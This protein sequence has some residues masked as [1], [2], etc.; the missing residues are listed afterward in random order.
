MRGKRGRPPKPL[1]AEEPSA[2]AAR[3]LRPR[4]NLK[5]RL[6][7]SGDEESPTRETPKSGRKRKAGSGTAA[8]GRGRGR[9]G[10]GGGGGRGGRGG[11]GGKRAPAS[12]TVVYD[13]HESDEEEDDAVSLRSD[14]EEF[15]EEDPQSE[16]DEALKEDSDCLEED[17]LGD[18]EDDASYCTESSFRSQSTHASTPGKKKVRAPRPRTPIL[19]EKEIPPL[20]LPDTS[21]DLLVPNEE[22]LNATSIYE[23]LRNFS[24]VLR[25]SPFRFEDF[26]AALVGQEQCTLI[27]ETHISLL[28]AIL[29]EEDSSNTTFGPADLK[30]SVNS[31]LYFIDGMT[32]PEVLRAYCES[33]Q[34]YHH[35]LPYLEVDEYPYGPLESKIKLLQFLVD[36]FLTT[37][38]AREELMSDGSMQYD[39][40][41]RVCHRLGDLLCCETCSAVYHL[42]CVKP[43]LEEVPEDEWQCEVCV[44][45]KVPGVT[46][47][48]TE[49]QKIRPYIRQEPVGYDRHQRKYWFLSRRIIVEEDGEH[50][51]KK[52][53]Y[54]STKAQ[55]E[56]LME[57]L[58]KEYWEMDLHATLVE[59]K[60]EV[61]A[62]MDITEDLTNKARGNN[63][64]YLTAVNELVM[65]HLKIR[66]EAQRLAEEPKEEAEKGSGKTA[67]DS[68]ESTSQPDDSE[69]NNAGPK[70]DT[71]S[72][73]ALVPPPAEESCTSHPDPGSASQDSAMPKAESLESSQDTQ[74]AQSRSPE[75]GETP[76][77][78]K[79]ERTDD[80]EKVEP[81][82]DVPHPEDSKPQTKDQ[83]Q[84]QTSQP[85]ASSSSEVSGS[86]SHAKAEPPD[87]AD[88]SSQS[89]FTSQDGTEEYNERVKTDPAKTAGQEMTNQTP[90]ASKESSAT[91]SDGESL[92]L[93]FL[94][95]DLTVNVNSLFKLGQEGKYRVYHNQYSTNVL[96]LNKH[97]HR[98]DHDK[99][100]HLSHKFSLTTASEFKWNG[101]IYGSRSLTVSTLRLT[102]IQLE[103]NV[104]G[105]FMHPNWASHRTNWNKAV[106]M[107]SK[108]REFALALAIL[109]CAIKPVVMLPV[110]KESLGHTRLHRMTSMEREEKEKVKKREKKL[111][112][113]ETLQQA[114]WVKYTIPIKHQVWKQKGEEYR[115]TGYGGWSWVSKTRVPRFVP[116]LPGNTNVNYR[117]KLEGKLSKENAA[118][119][120]NKQKRLMETKEQNAAEED[121]DQLKKQ[122]PSIEEGQTSTE[123]EKPVQEEQEKCVEDEK[124]E[125]DP[126]SEVAASK[127]DKD[128][129]KSPSSPA[130]QPVGEEPIQAV[131]EPKTEETA[132]SKPYYDVV[133]VSEGF[134]L[135]TAY[136]KKVKP[137][138]LDGL[139]ER[140]VKQFTLEEKQRLERMR[141]ATFVSK[142]ATAKPNSGIKSESTALGRQQSAVSPCVKVEEKEDG[143]Q[144]KDPVV[145]K[146]DFEQEAKTDVKSDSTAANHSK[147]TGAVQENSTEAKA[148]REVNGGRLPGAEL[149][150]KSN[151][152]SEDLETKE[153]SQ[154]PEVTRVG[155]NAKKRGYEEVEQGGG[156]S[157]TEVLGGDESKVSPMQVNGQPPADT[158]S[159]AAARLQ[160]DARETQK[161]PLKSLMNGNLCPN[162]ESD[163]CHPPPLKV[164]KLENHIAE[165]GDSSCKN[166]D[167][168]TASEGTTKVPSSS[169]SCLNSNKTDN[170][171]SETSIATG[172][173]AGSV[174]SSNSKADVT[175]PASSGVASSVTAAQPSSVSPGGVV[176]QKTKLPVTDPKM[177]ACG[178]NTA[179]S[180][181][182]SKEYSTRDRVSLLRFSKSKKARSGTALPSYR[183]FVTKSSKKS[184]FVLPN[185]DL[186]RLARRAGFREVPIFN[187][188]AKPA[189]DIWP[190]P[191]PRPTF[192][193]TWRYRL[194]TVRSLAGVSLMLRLLWACLRWDDMAVKP[195]AVV[196]TTRKETTDTDITTTEIIKR[197]DVGPYGIRSEYCI[198]KIICPLGNRDTHKETPT[199]QRKGL[200]SSALRPKKQEPAKL[201]GPIAVETWV[202]EEEL[203]LWEIRAFAERVER[204]KSQGLDPSKTGSSLK[205][206][207]EVK[208]H[209]ENQLKQARLAAQQ[210]RLEQQRPSTPA[211]TSTTTA[212]STAS[213]STP[214]AP[215]ST[216]Q[217]MG[218]VASG[219]KMVLASK[220]GSPVSFQQDKNF[221]QS[222]ASWVK[223][224][225]TNNSAGVVQQKVLGIFPSG[226]P[227]NLRTYS[228]LHPTTGN[229]N[230]RATTSA[231]AA[232]Q[233]ATAAGGQT[234][235][236]TPTLSTSVGT[237]VARSPAMVQQAHPQQAVTRMGLGLSAATAAPG[238]TPAQMAATQRAVAPAL[239]P[240]VAT[241]APGQSPVAPSQAN[242]PQQGQVKLT[243]AQLMQLTQGAQ[244]ANPGLTVVI[245]GQG[246][247]QGQLQIIPQ[248]VT[249]IPGPGQQLMQAAMPNGQV[250]RF[251]FT[252]MPP[253]SS[254]ATSAPATATT[255]KPAVAQTPQTQMPTSASTGSLAQVQTTPS[256]LAHTQM[257]APVPAPTHVVAPASAQ[258]PSLAPP[259]ASVPVQ[260]AANV[261]APVQAAAHQA[262]MQTKVSGVPPSSVPAQSQIP[263]SVPAL[264]QV[265]AQTSIISSLTTQP[266]VARSEAPTAQNSAPAVTQ[267]VFISASAPAPNE[268][269]L[270]A[271]VQTQVST[272]PSASFPTQ[273]Q[274]PVSLPVVG[275][276]AP[277]PQVQTHAL[278]STPVTASALSPVL[279][280]SP[281]QVAAT[282]TLAAAT[283]SAQVQAAASLPSAVPVPTP[284][285]APVS[286]P[287]VA[288]VSTQIPVPSP[289]KALTQIQT[290]AAAPLHAAVASA[291][292][293]PVTATSTT[294]SVPELR[295]A[296]PQV[297]TPAA[298][299]AQTPV[300]PV[301]QAAAPIQA[302]A[303]V[304]VPT[305]PPPSIS[306]HSPITTLPHSSL[307][308]LAPQSQAQVQHPTVVSM[309]QVSQIPVSAV[310][311]HMQGLPVSSVVTAVRPPQPH[312]QPQT[313]TQLQHQ[314]QA[315]IHAQIQ[316]QP[317]GQVQQIQAQAHLQS[318]TQAQIQPQVRVQFQPRSQSQQTPQPQV[319]PLAQIQPQVQFQSQSQSLPQVQAP[320]QGQLQ[321]RVQPQYHPQVQGSFQTQLQ[322]QPQAQQQPQVQPQAQVQAQS[323]A[324]TQIQTQLH[325]QVQVQ[326][327]QQSQIQAQQPQ[328]PSQV[329]TH[330]HF[331]VQSPQQ[332]QVQGQ[333]QV[334]AK[335][336]VQFQPQN[337]T[338]VQPQPQLQVQSPIR[339]QLITVPGLQQ[340]V[341]LLSALP[342]HV[343]AQIQAQIQAQA[344]QQGGT[345]PQQIKLQLPIQI[346]Q[347]GGQI[348]AHQIQNMVTI[349]APVNVQEQLQRMQQ[350]QQ[351]Q[352]QHPPPPKKKKPHESKKEQKEQNVHAVSPGDGIQKQV[353][354]KQNAT[355]EQLKQR[356]TLAAAEREENQ[357]MIVCNQVMKFILDKIEKDEK[358][359]AKKRK[360]E[361]V[362][363][364]KRSKQ[365]ATKLTALLYKHKE[366]LKAEILKKRALLDKELQLQVQEELRR[367]IARLQKEKEKAR[368]AIAQAA[369]ATVKA[370]SSHSSHPS[371][372]THSSHS[373][374]TVTS[375]SSSHIRKREE[376]RD[377][378]RNRDRD[379]HHD[380]EK[381]RDRDKDRDRHRDRDKDRERE[382]ERERDR[383]RD[384]DKDRDR[385][386]D[387]DRDSSS[388]KHKKKKKH[389]STSKDHKKDTKLYCICKTPY[390]ESKFYIGC[391]LCSNWFHGTCVG[392]TEK[393]AK[394]LEDFVCNDCKRGQEAGSSEELYCICRTPYDESQFYIGCDRCQN[395]YHG[396]C[397]GILQSE[398]NHIDVY[399]CPQCQS[400]EDAMTVLTPLTDKDYEGLK[401][402]LRSLQ[403]H[404]MA[405]P[406]LEPVD[407]HDAPDYYRV[408]KE[409]M[410]F[411][412]METRLQKR[413]Y[414]KLTEFVADVT[415]IFDNCRYYNPNDT[416]FFQCAEVL[417]AF[418]VQKLKGFKASR[419]SDS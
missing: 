286:A 72:Q 129:N 51:K 278:T 347:T 219:T 372:S 282:P 92:R 84:Q 39:D 59:M 220:L 352:Q 276:A 238:S 200:R 215:L 160:G 222:F 405:W 227:A 150:S 411:S 283:N 273:T 229:I 209:L 249:V 28:K 217:R 213:A 358:Q 365:N 294:P 9:G 184:I 285:L 332:T 207:E 325:P 125:V 21:E 375:P 115:V 99:R 54:Y 240:R 393:E 250:Q 407:P 239:S 388:S 279:V 177:N 70:A 195:S 49:A 191:S 265:A 60:E 348:Q 387:K 171:S 68:A 268:A 31:T 271:M 385:D 354:V 223:Q 383:H 66:R 47:C 88:R 141:Q 363:E 2:A 269:E 404:K 172:V 44:A 148:H 27:A 69:H 142:M 101:S 81:S 128:E 144:A 94:K 198:R 296:Q 328:V 364:Q 319:Q 108:A 95:R 42:E 53:W 415:K 218:Q 331:Q 156:Q 100:R 315:Q 163:M 8:R 264:Q 162:D 12:K 342:A 306:T 153:K 85:E 89:S 3:G 297:W 112:D 126:C 203:E 401:R 194:Q 193:I 73:A 62:H 235:P 121:E 18:E 346:Q 124:M 113:E 410:D 230:L 374:H 48:V 316:V 281:V 390:D 134:Q 90:T 355:A 233:Q 259:P 157:D 334:Q 104:P 56:E 137:S 15:V 202:A 362:V 367:D 252:P 261:P 87:L 161:E 199:P 197:R 371:H 19:E 254:A 189:L 122:S 136:K 167:K 329:Q 231:S 14:D 158:S 293:T 244:G 225:Q 186:K 288:I 135:R 262:S 36:Q 357:R 173:P 290:T 11:R 46:D 305:P 414:H 170:C 116:K 151:C 17:A 71:G 272:V 22:L 327:Q 109:E 311:V 41:C 23:V 382:R 416:P 75:S 37:N 399:V 77:V 67:G 154:K 102:I 395:W 351:Q 55:L 120:T 210:K 413:H 336:Q 226:P 394:K 205:T 313:N 343:A 187:Y 214:S 211:S 228:T 204:E 114:T 63:K 196:G 97:Q 146:L 216:G 320:A 132:A 7:D 35:V 152:I 335:I 234:Q 396:R 300:H 340:P 178:S 206:A 74:A 398:A 182:I 164:P 6:R 309:Q 412:T 105:P 183:K 299:Q 179:S 32:W 107:C 40:H 406:F 165:K 345:V 368:A 58:D 360:K 175:S 79:Q 78:A 10:G 243:M 185:D 408:I 123:E 4:R 16:E 409:P 324:T 138:K 117:K 344:Q 322:T 248:G 359:A 400:T 103:T 93:S 192:G 1:Q 270:P 29:R 168:V 242:R 274:T 256:A 253:S 318:Q 38:I 57:R 369:A 378:D 127:D 291:V 232:Q 289:A 301:Q 391:D 245:Q 82:M 418:F 287:V 159:T 180:M 326:F 91:C 389:S 20:E 34:E 303:Q 24:T 308:P 266:Q 397:V 96:A 212:T 341:Q 147:E 149:N 366:Q 370:A 50:V 26:C 111:E 119:C 201:T 361:E 419:L 33:D 381:K 307:I 330:P 174:S 258:M 145:K 130:L 257:T 323:Q 275:Q 13:D 379:R 131:E 110:W 61:Q 30:D 208:A 284:A 140:R 376:E 260:V 350:Q 139:L 241:T 188:S 80:S 25:L 106:Q 98:E 224:G 118:T 190:Y 373:A 403:S 280:R 337:Q 45:H 386:R 321:S 52:I 417:E 5:P 221:H 263:T 356:K 392:I 255:A 246:Q 338:Q 176:S 236:V 76:L 317:F 333:S 377:K 83:P 169:R 298:S 312:P 133:N 384:R 402:I 143:L 349:Q 155:E 251:L 310:Q 304:T 292:V 86:G 339:H 65:E 353:V 237:T 380:K 166:E 277:Q 314:P 295:T 181:T 247:T 43:P 267:R 64:A 302:P